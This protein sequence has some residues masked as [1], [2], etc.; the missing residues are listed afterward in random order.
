MFASLLSHLLRYIYVLSIRPSLLSG[1]RR[2]EIHGGET[3]A[4]ALAIVRAKCFE[5]RKNASVLSKKRVQK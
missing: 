1:D 3:P 2:F 4:D 5:N